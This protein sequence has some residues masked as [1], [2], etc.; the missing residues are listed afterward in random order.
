MYV[1]MGMK[2]T[3]IIITAFKEKIINIKKETI[4]VS[5]NS[6]SDRN[7]L[8]STTHIKEEEMIKHRSILLI[9]K[10]RKR[11]WFSMNS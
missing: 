1:F 3:I 5:D 6:D 4:F 2:Q 7:A 10:P 9:R 8:Q 11:G